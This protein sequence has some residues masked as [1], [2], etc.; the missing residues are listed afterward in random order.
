MTVYE[1]I[2]TAVNVWVSTPLSFRLNAAPVVS[3]E[4][5]PA[6]LDVNGNAWSSPPGLVCLMTVT[7]PQLLMFTGVG[8]MKSFIV[9]LNAVDERL[10]T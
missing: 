7:V 5:V 3:G 1:P 6:T 4:P 2:G 10:L 9:A 8:A